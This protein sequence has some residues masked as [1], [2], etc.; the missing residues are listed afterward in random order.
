MP[1]L[2][3]ECIE[4]LRTDSFAIEPNYFTAD[5]CAQLQREALALADDPDS[6]DA[7][8]GRGGR[9]VTDTRI[10]R[11]RIKWLTGATPAQ[12]EF[13]AQADVLREAIN[14]RLFLGL[15]EFEAQFA[16]TPVGG[17]YA[18]HLDS[19]EGTRNR[20]VS[21]VTYLDANWREGDGGVLRIWTP[22]PCQA[23]MP[24]TIDVLPDR[25]TLVLMLSESVPHE[26]LTSNRTRSSIAGW[27]RIRA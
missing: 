1:A 15:F 9:H 22:E 5:L 27:F 13:L 26:V 25:G 16:L 3:R 7:G 17:F 19:F 4:R 2:L 20:V 6:I 24:K 21:L 8:V 12:A 18:R 10:R 11:A 23:G 14:R